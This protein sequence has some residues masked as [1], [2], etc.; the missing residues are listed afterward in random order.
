MRKANITEV[1]LH[2]HTV[3]RAR[4]T[5]L[6]PVELCRAVLGNERDLGPRTADHTIIKQL[7]V[8]VSHW[9][10]IF[11]FGFTEMMCSI[12]FVLNT[13]MF[14]AGSIFPMHFMFSNCIVI[15]NSLVVKHNLVLSGYFM[16]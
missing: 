2:L 4:V 15:I 14:K 3:F 13:L 1:H 6:H 11:L 12:V 5:M 16:F 9:C 10:Y 7:V 8:Y